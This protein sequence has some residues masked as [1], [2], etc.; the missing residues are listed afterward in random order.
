MR[1]LIL[2]ALLV[3]AAAMAAEPKAAPKAVP[4]A[5]AS[6]VAVAAP[7]YGE[8][9]K[10]LREQVKKDAVAQKEM[11]KSPL[12]VP[13]DLGADATTRRLNKKTA[14]DDFTLKVEPSAGVALEFTPLPIDDAE[15][16]EL[17]PAEQCK[18]MYFL[19]Y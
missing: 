7:T 13:A 11:A 10:L 6:K 12:A 19:T 5:E 1:G 8:C 15:K 3:P 16:T 2:L 18:A 17:T 9:F 14:T 4:K